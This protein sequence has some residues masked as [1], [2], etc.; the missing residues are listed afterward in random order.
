M[1]NTHGCLSGVESV[2]KL[3]PRD[4]AANDDLYCFKQGLFPKVNT[5]CQKDPRELIRSRSQGRLRRD[6]GTLKPKFFLKLH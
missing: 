6:R 4:A 2:C 5:A 3:E 1:A